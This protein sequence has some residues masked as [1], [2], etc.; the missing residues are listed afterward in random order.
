V[1]FQFEGDAATTPDISFNVFL[2]DSVGRVLKF[3]L[4]SDYV[5]NPEWQK[6]TISLD[7]FSEEEWDAG[8][9]TAAPDADKADIVA[10]GLMVVGNEVNQTANYYV[11]DI[12]LNVK[13]ENM[14]V[15]NFE[16]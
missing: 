3:A 1:E 7:S 11:D 6:V 13:P 16:S 5:S 8:Y 15:D 2:Y 4:P 14:A 10:L 12:K 9:G